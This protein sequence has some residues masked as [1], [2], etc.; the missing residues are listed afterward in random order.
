MIIST[1]RYD[2]FVLTFYNT[3]KYLPSPS[4]L[5][6]CSTFSI[7]IYYRAFF[8]IETEELEQRMRKYLNSR[9]RFISSKDIK[10]F[11][12]KIR[13]IKEQKSKVEKVI[14]NKDETY[15]SDFF[16]WKSYCRGEAKEY[17]F[18]NY[19]EY[20]DHFLNQ[21]E[22]NLDYLNS[23]AS[24]QNNLVIILVAVATLMATLA[25]IIITLLK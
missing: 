17:G 24:V 21:Y 7:E 6:Y 16:Q 18:I 19:P 13:Y 10:W 22:Q 9:K 2:R 25:G 8:H 3:G 15:Y 23:I 14:S 11:I 4:L 5:Q 1:L 12:N 20:T